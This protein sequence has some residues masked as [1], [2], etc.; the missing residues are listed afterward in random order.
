MFLFRSQA[1]CL[2]G[3]ACLPLTL[4][5][6]LGLGFA[7]ESVAPQR[8]T[9][10]MF[11]ANA[12]R[13]LANPFER[14]IPGEWNVQEGKRKNIKWSAKLSTKAYGG[15]VVAGGK[16]YVATDNHEPHNPKITGDKGIVL[17]FRESDGALLWEAAHDEL[18]NEIVKEARVEGIASTPT[19][20]GKR[21]YYVSN[22][23]ELIC[24]ST[25]GVHPA[26]NA[27]ASATN[28]TG[29]L[30]ADIIWRLDMIKEL[31]VFPHKLPNCSPLLVG[32]SLFVT[33]GNGTDGEGPDARAPHPEAPS[34]I[35]VNKQSGKVVWQ[36]NSP[37]DNIVLGQ[38][39]NPA[40]AL[41]AGKPQVI[42]AGGD[43]WLR[44]FE[45]ATGKHIWKFNCIPPA[46]GKE[47]RNYLVAT[48]A[49]YDSKVYVGIGQEP[50]QGT[51]VGHLWC[52]DAS[53]TGDVSPAAN[54]FDP[55]APEKKNSALV[56]HYGGAAKPQAE[57]DI[58]F[59]RT[60]STCAIHD[61]LVY[62]AEL[63]GYVHCLD[64][65]TGQKYWDHDLKA[66]IWGSP[67]WVDGKIYIGTADGDIHVFAHGKQK[68][69][70]A[71][72]EMEDAIYST[73]TAANGVLFVA[74]MKNLYA[75]AP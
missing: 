57:R 50:S 33:T 70:L 23:C 66:E 47:N 27:G 34:F 31:N 17:C 10:A 39:S 67:Y 64:A 29:P 11:G 15:P 69:L 52:V 44:A 59:G 13:N 74:T 42:F 62:A 48:P 54:V 38:W 63:A 9:L 22:R 46:E 37:G 56:W 32:D 6:G 53:R 4:A 7:D 21:L 55:K 35:A 58:V 2:A 30:D 25:E 3:L 49:V 60:L 61:G 65:A 8:Q 20:E 19:I 45:P 68:R 28:E 26:K 36:D 43:G 71:K 41:V 5:L 75:I 40:F 72:N 51:G 24:A 16:V 73:P 12:H 1:L 18:P 14:N